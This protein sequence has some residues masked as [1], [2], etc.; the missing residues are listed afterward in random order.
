MK[1]KLFHLWADWE[2]DEKNCIRRRTCRNK[3]CNECYSEEEWHDFGNWEYEKP[4]SCLQIRRCK[5]TGCCKVETGMVEHQFEDW[6][7]I[8]SD[9]C[10]Q[11]RKCRRCSKTETYIADHQFGEWEYYTEGSCGQRCVCRHCGYTKMRVYHR[12][13]EVRILERECVEEHIC[14]VCGDSE[15]VQKEH[16]WS[17]MMPYKKSLQTAISSFKKKK[18]HLESVLVGFK[19]GDR[20][21]FGN[22]YWMAN[23]ELGRLNGEIESLEQKILVA[24]DNDWGRICLHCKRIEYLGDDRNWK[25]TKGFMSYSHS[26]REYADFLDGKLK[27]SG[28]YIT[29]DIRDL[30][31]GN[32]LQQFMGRVSESEYVVVILSD[33]YFCSENCMYEAV[34]VVHTM[35]ERECKLIIY[36]IGLSIAQKEIQEKYQAYWQ[37]KLEE[38]VVKNESPHKIEIYK[39]ICENIWEFMNLAAKHKYEKVDGIRDIDE[40]KVRDMVRLIVQ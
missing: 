1:K 38:A 2:Y 35:A 36:S 15:V 29:R 12:E 22:E 7:Y 40:K 10:E 25:R 8:Q 18:E 32:N 6:E 30:N 33:A 14:P 37:N 23:A 34:K 4:G 26:D 3:K 19:S 24:G 28:L 13:R 9:S 17:K 21:W 20:E 11:I 5:R 39:G 31:V 16:E 27:E